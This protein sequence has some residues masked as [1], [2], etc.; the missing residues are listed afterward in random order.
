MTGHS[1]GT[2]HWRVW[3]KRTIKNNL[4]NLFN[5]L[6][7]NKIVKCAIEQLECW[8]EWSKYGT[9]CLT[10]VLF[11]GLQWEV[12]KFF[13]FMLTVFL[14]NLASASTAFF[15]SARFKVTGL[16]NLC[17][18]LLFVIQMVSCGWFLL[19]RLTHYHLHYIAWRLVCICI[20]N[21]NNRFFLV[22]S[23]LVDF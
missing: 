4:K 14:T 3:L 12:D 23:C 2:I 6:G 16:A 9:H 7:R 20:F 1:S 5:E 13:I 11:A 17:V 21:S 19:L 8:N 18:A 10:I 15:V 22:S